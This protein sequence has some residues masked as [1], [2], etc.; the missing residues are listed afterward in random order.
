MGTGKTT[1]G[2]LLADKLGME[3]VDTDEVIEARHGDITEIFR[4]R[5]ESTFRAIERELVTELAERE[6]LVISTGGRMLLDPDN[7][8]SLS[9]T[10]RVFCL[11]ATP[12]EIFQRVENDADRAERPLLQVSDPRQRIVEMLAEREDGYRR[13]PQL[14][15]SGKTPESVAR[16][17]VDIITS[18]QHR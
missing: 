11:V 5:G 10:G 8:A 6:G 17:L 12:D 9:R 16:E 15:T 18:D 13:F 7:A 4:T 14:S 3:F 2:R 1:I